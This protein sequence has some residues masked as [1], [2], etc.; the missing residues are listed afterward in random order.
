MKYESPITYHLKDMTN[1]K[2]FKKY[3][4]LQGQVQ[5]V[6]ILLSIERSCHKE[7]SYEIWKPYL[8]L[9]KRYNQY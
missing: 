4:N 3:A 2:V 7:Y 1:F 6:K 8:L 9:I 5:D